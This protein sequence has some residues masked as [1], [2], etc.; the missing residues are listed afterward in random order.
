MGEMERIAKRMREAQARAG[1]REHK[2][3]RI[4]LDPRVELHNRQMREEWFDGFWRGA[5]VFFGLGIMVGGVI[6]ELWQW[7]G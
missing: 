1:M 6:A 4:T 7:W 2:E 5:G 3:V